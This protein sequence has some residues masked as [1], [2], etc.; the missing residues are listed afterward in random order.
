MR[1]CTICIYF[2]RGKCSLKWSCDFTVAKKKEVED[3]Q[4]H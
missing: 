4:V 1:D 3:E 2:E